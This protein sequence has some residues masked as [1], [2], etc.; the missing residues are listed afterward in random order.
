[1]TYKLSRK[2]SNDIENI[3][4]YTLKEWSI[5][6]ADRYIKLIFEEIEYL[7]KNPNSGKD[8]GYVRENYRFS[9]VKSH[10]IFYR[11]STI[12]SKIEIIRILHQEMDIENR[13]ED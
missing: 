1:M 7:A 5:K 8:Y 3:W 4:I 10:I 12:D 9:K 13:L 6:Q 2:A 11:H